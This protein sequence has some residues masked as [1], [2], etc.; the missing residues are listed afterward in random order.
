MLIAVDVAAEL[1]EPDAA[2]Q[3]GPRAQPKH[4]PLSPFQ[5]VLAGIQ[6]SIYTVL[7]FAGLGPATPF[8]FLL[9]VFALSSIA[10]WRNVRLWYR[11]GIDFEA[12][13]YD[14]ET[15]EAIRRDRA[16]GMADQDK[17]RS[18]TAY[19][20]KPPCRQHPRG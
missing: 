17:M 15:E 7:I 2:G 8:I 5:F 9:P 12:R 16:A 13:L 11:Q 18:V 19:A 1:L 3:R 20:G 10:A 6:A 4:V 14:F